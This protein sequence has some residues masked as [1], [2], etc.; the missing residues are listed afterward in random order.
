VIV[1]ASREA[2]SSDFIH[3]LPLWHFPTLAILLQAP[4]LHWSCLLP[5]PT[6][7]HACIMNLNATITHALWCETS[8]ANLPYKINHPHLQLCGS[9]E[10]IFVLWIL[11]SLPP[12]A[13]SPSHLLTRSPLVPAWQ[14][15]CSHCHASMQ[16]WLMKLRNSTCT[17]SS[18]ASFLL[19]AGAT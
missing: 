12:R 3:P 13:W 15:V 1:L 8:M 4:V 5:S 18:W 11:G 10:T 16:R 17:R 7:Y 19:D 9:W 6:S 2:T 14:A